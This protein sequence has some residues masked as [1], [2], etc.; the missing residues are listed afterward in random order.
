MML[1]IMQVAV[2]R[3]LVA[4]SLGQLESQELVGGRGHKLSRFSHRVEN[5]AH[6]GNGNT[7]CVPF[8]IRSSCSRTSARREMK[9]S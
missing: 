8:D 2:D 1:D 3:R 4:Q 9:V 6:D 7:P 5:V